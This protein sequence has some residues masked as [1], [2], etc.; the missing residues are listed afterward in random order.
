MKLV[1]F[2][3]DGVL[4][5]TLL[6]CYE[7]TKEANEGMSMETFRSVSSYNIPDFFKNNSNIKYHPHFYERY[8]TETRELKIPDSIKN[9]IK[10]LSHGYKLAIVTSTPSRLVLKILQQA[11]V[12]Q[13]F[14][15]ILGRD[16]H[17][18]KVTKNKM[19]LEKYKISVAEAVYVTDTT[20][21]IKE[22]RECNISSIAVT[23]GF[24]EEK[25]LKK[26]NPAKVVNTPSELISA[27]KEL[28]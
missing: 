1:I 16:I 26:A 15:D 8:E 3:F 19:L 17:T 24:H 10:D 21:D 18:S 22:A 9:L 11:E 5:D 28:L 13:Y 25:T 6:M 27:I 12:D 20:G 4:V 2:D 23:W 7:I 14:S